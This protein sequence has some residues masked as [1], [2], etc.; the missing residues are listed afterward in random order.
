[1]GEYEDFVKKFKREKTTDDCMTPPAVYEAVKDWV[2]KEW[3]IDDAVT[4]VRP[5][6]PG[7]D[8]EKY[9]YPENC[10]VIDNPPFSIISK[11]KRFYNDRKIKFFLF[12]PALTLC[13]SYDDK[14]NYII[15]NARTTYENG[16]TVSTS[17]ITNLPGSK[18]RICGPLGEI[19]RAADRNAGTTKELPKY[20]YPENVTSAARLGKL[21]RGSVDF[22]FE[23]CEI[24][25]V[26][27]LDAQKGK[28]IFGGG[29]L[30]SDQAAERLREAER[31]ERFELSETEK[32]IIDR[33]TKQSEER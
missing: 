28:A 33:L 19:V 11:I 10:I 27:K 32:E 3:K 14:T 31:R 6:W 16:A 17:F 13:S 25:K 8:Y 12:A 20:E 30:I 5:F 1:M 18:V 21:A 26:S 9:E 24:H 15:T 7:G 4:I 22:A 23:T 2:K 29:F